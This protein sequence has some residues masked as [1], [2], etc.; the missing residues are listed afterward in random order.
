MVLE[1]V[2]VGVLTV[3][4]RVRVSVVVSVEPV[5]SSCLMVNFRIVVAC[6]TLQHLA[7]IHIVI[8][9][10]REASCVVW[11]VVGRRVLCSW[12]LLCYIIVIVV[13]LLI[14]IAIVVVIVVGWLAVFAARGEGLA[15]IRILRLRQVSLIRVLV[16]HLHFL[17]VHQTALQLIIVLVLFIVVVLDVFLVV[18]AHFDLVGESDGSVG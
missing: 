13:C 5:T 11:S 4:V 16:R 10:R 14:V 7:A 2:V 3:A 17:H 18:V 1:L 8:V 15:W 6:V 12:S 9:A